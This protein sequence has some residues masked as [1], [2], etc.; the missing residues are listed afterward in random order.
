MFAKISLGT[1]HRASAIKVTSSLDVANVGYVAFLLRVPRAWLRVSSRT[2]ALLSPACTLLP[3]VL[4]RG[5]IG[6]RL[7]FDEFL[8]CTTM[9]V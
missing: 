6:F 3:F 5:R 2:R 7:F 1:E 4:G 9:V 8:T